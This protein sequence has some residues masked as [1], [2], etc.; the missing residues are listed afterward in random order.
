MR[1]WTKAITLFSIF[2]VL[3]LIYP[4]AV[5]ALNP[6]KNLN[7]YLLRAWTV[8]SGL[9]QNT[10]NALLQSHEGYI[11][12]GTSAGL[13]RFDGVRFK[14]FSRWNTPAL[15]N[16]RILAL[17]EDRNNVLW[18]GTDGG[19]L[20]SLID[21]TWRNYATQDG[22]SNNHVRAI[23]GDW[24]DYLWVGTE[25]GLNRLGLDG[26]RIYTTRDGLYDNLIT[27]LSFDDWGSLWI[28]TMRGG[29]AQLS[30]KVTRIY[31]YDD[32]LLNMAV[33][34]LAADRMGNI[35]IGTLEGLFS[36]KRETGAVTLISGTTYTPITAIHADE[37]GTLWIGTMADGLKRMSKV[38]VRGLS[39]K[40]GFPDDFI[41]SILQDR[42]G[43]LWIGTDSGGLVQLKDARV[44]IITPNNGLPENTVY[45]VLQDHEGSLWIGMRNS[46]LCQMRDNRV[47]EIIGSKSGLSSERIR[48]LFE[49]S[50]HGLWIG[51]E[52]G[53]INILRN[54][55]L[56]LLT[57]KDGLP[58]N[59]ITAILQD[60]TGKFW[61]GTDNGL[62]RLSEGRVQVSDSLTGLKNLHIR[63]LL[64][65]RE[66]VLYA[67][68]KEGLFKFTGQSFE[69]VDAE[70]E[71]SG[72]DVVSLYEDSEGVLWIGTNGNGLK[73]WLK[74]KMTSFTA[75]K[76]LLD[77]YIFSIAE[78]D[79]QNLWMSSS[80]GVF[81]VSRKELRDFSEQKIR[82]VHST[83][84]DEAD[85]M[86]SRQCVGFGQPSFWKTS[87]GQLYFPT[88]RGV[89][90]FDP[91]SMAIR[92]EPPE[93]VIED[94]LADNKP[95]R[96][97]ETIA[98][99]HKVGMLEFHFTALDFSAPDKIRFKYKL[100]GCDPDFVDVGA[101]DRRAAT[102]PRLDPGKYRFLV[103][104][105]NN[106]SL[107]NEEGASFEF[108]VLSPVYS[109]PVFYVALFLVALF[110]SGIGLFIHYQ[111]KS[112][113]RMEKYRTSALHPEKAEEIVPRLLHLM[114]EERLFL[115][116]DLT[117]R[118]L[119]LRLRI[120]YNHLSR[121]INERFGLSYNDFINKY[122]IEEAKRKLA[123]PEEKESTILDILLST[124]FYSKSVFNAA[125]KKFEG[126]TPSRY[127]KKYLR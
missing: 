9:P 29:L 64:E 126:T 34:S 91:K 104:A 47:V 66:G 54:G 83:A 45:A 90:I 48:V 17:Y 14:V 46:G 99:S 32:G 7:E 127:R 74:G 39:A 1:G 85:G 116:P 4:H 50:G 2:Y 40:D 36:L 120:H 10:I 77:N 49:D 18:I 6:A 103:K 80:K 16:D 122:R 8:E 121:I 21:G 69:R 108:K 44:K 124:G 56:A 57:T 51:T 35:L 73:R 33:I 41:H 13:V 22:L 95:V 84:Y 96:G 100:E 112:G 31:G 111:K 114:E 97:E 62:A 102:Y 20:C 88:V 19:G 78:D 123:N 106:D 76:G 93:V 92:K 81:R 58:S 52:G 53:G 79:N 38:T 72:I 3:I 25:Y 117:L 113:K 61:V 110:I 115:D 24:Q 43:N 94:V 107:W 28:G 109:K 5:P 67:G 82:S 11:W 118:E 26:F 71:G 37:Q 105:V 23:T 125:F 42:E 68:T 12:M 30:Q 86:A 75:E 89:A 87:S 15:K 65:S 59:T 98:L 55:R 70:D 101:G 60:S 27:A 63:V 119:S